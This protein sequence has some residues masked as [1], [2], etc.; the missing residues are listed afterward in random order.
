MDLLQFQIEKELVAMNPSLDV[1][2]L[3]YDDRKA[4]VV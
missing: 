3:S 1:H 4:A 2:G